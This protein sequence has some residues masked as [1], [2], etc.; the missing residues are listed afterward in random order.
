VPGQCP[1]PGNTE[2][3]VGWDSEQPGLVEDGPAHCRGVGQDDL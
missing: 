2:A 1:L 3:Q